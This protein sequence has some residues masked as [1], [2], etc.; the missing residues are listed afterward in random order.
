M[1]FTSVAIALLSTSPS[2]VRGKEELLRRRD[3]ANTAL[4]WSPE[5]V[6]R[7]DSDGFV[8]SRDWVTGEPYYGDKSSKG[9]KSSNSNAP[10]SHSSKGPK[11]SKAPH[12]PPQP[13]YQPMPP[14]EHCPDPPKLE[15]CEFDASK[16]TCG[17]HTSCKTGM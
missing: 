4:Q 13:H 9:H 12:Y 17:L 1:K 8:R 2:I 15:H 6:G 5:G 3:L 7:D 10:E 14:E 16:D 11:S